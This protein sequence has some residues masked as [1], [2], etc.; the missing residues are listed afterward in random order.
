MIAQRFRWFRVWLM[1]SRREAFAALV[2]IALVGALA[3]AFIK[4]PVGSREA[5]FGPEWDCKYV[6]QGDPVCIKRPPATNPP[7]PSK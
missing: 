5:G 4:Y 1:S 7:A 6:G 2:L 3:F